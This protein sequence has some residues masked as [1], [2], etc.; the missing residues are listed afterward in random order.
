MVM[1]LNN[2]IRRVFLEHRGQFLGSIAIVILASL[3]FTSMTHF[4]ANFERLANELQTGYAQ[5]DA[6]FTTD[7][8]IADLREL[9]SAANATVEE[10][11]S[12]DYRLDDGNTLRIFSENERVNL[13]AV[14][15]GEALSSGT[16]LLNPVFAEP[17]NYRIGDQLRV[18]GKRFT[19]S[20]FVVLPNYIYPLE[21]DVDMM[22]RPGFG[23]AVITKQDFEALGQGSSF[24]AVKF[25]QAGGDPAPSTTSSGSCSRTG[26]LRLHSGR[27]STTT[28]GSTSSPRRSRSSASSA[29]LCP[30]L[31]CCWRASW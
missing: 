2:R 9:E 23:G 26:A 31:C 18:L 8:K 20:G 3:A 16:I 11:R 27:A 13:S 25:N 28:S 7:R 5:E 15:A 6:T 30:R 22:P 24:Y 1:A 12:L 10:G 21:S 19:V 4:A 29:E 14:V 17:N